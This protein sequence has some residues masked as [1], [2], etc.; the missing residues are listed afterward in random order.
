[1]KNIIKSTLGVIEFVIVVLIVSLI[2][3]HYFFNND[4]KTENYDSNVTYLEENGTKCNNKDKDAFNSVIH[5]NK[6]VGTYSDGSKYR[7]E[8]SVNL[9]YSKG[10]NMNKYG[11]DICETQ[12]INGKYNE[13]FDGNDTTFIHTKDPKTE[14][15]YIFNNKK[16]VNKIVI[17]VPEE[18]LNSTP[19]SFV[20]KAKEDYNKEWVTIYE[21]K[22]TMKNGKILGDKENKS[23]TFNFIN[24]KAYKSYKISEIK[25]YKDPFEL[26]ISELKIYN[27]DLTN[28]DDKQ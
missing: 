27:A 20:I 26:K 16:I 1:M 9:A 5:N 11:I 15:G 2:F 17:V 13:V 14:L 6:C 28:N 25:S 24:N 21:V 3:F 8:D 23:M 7:E 19:K 18:A 12:S 22:N 4:K 10:M